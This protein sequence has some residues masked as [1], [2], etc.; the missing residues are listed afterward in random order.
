[1]SEA[2][3]SDQLGDETSIEYVTV[4]I[5]GQLF[6]MPISKVEDVFTLQS[7][8]EVP[9]ARS[10]VAGVLNLRGRIVTAIDMRARLG[11]PP[12]ESEG[13]PMA[14]GVAYKSESYGLVIDTVGEVLRLQKDGIE[15]NPANLDPRWRQVSAGVHKLEGDLMV[16]LDIEQVLEGLTDPIAA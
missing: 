12:R 4:L 2:L 8:T 13:N 9:L 11:L 7:I 6:G 1:M 10:E 5:S 15:P 16:V 3:K 14:V